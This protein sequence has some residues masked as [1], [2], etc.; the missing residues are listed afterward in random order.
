[1]TAKEN[2][3][4]FQDKESIDDLELGLIDFG[5]RHY[6]PSIAR[7]TVQDPLADDRHWL[8]PYNFVQNNP[9]I[10]IDPDGMLDDIIHIDGQDDIVIET[11]DPYDNHYVLDDGGLTYVGTT[12][13][14]GGLTVL[15]GSA[16]TVEA[17]YTGPRAED[18]P[19]VQ[20]A[21]S[22]A[23]AIEAANTKYPG[24]AEPFYFVE[25]PVETIASTASDLANGDFLMAGASTLAIVL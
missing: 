8:S 17:S 6:D 24:T 18:D 21:Q 19:F 9:V 23:A 12:E 3:W 22:E 7:W 15:D 11:D 5:W 14:G 25:T 10:L 13:K 2:R 4:K 20:R 16:V 1:M